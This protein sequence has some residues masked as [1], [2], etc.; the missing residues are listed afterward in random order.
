MLSGCPE[1]KV[2]GCI[3][4]DEGLGIPSRHLGLVTAEE[5]PLPEEFLHRLAAVVEQHVD[6][7]AMLESGAGHP[8]PGVQRAVPLR[9]VGHDA[10]T[11][12]VRIAVARDAAFC[13]VYADNLRLLQQAGAEIIEFSPLRDEGLPAGI[14]GLYLPGGYPEVFA[15]QLAANV[16]MKEA[17]RA[18]IE[19]GMPTYAECGG[20]IYLTQG[21]R[22]QGLASARSGHPQGV[23]LHELV[24]VYPVAASMLPRRKALGYR[25]IT[26]SADTVLGPAG[27][28]ARGHEFHYSEMEPMPAAVEC[29]YRVRRQDVD[30]GVEGFRYRHCLASYVHLH[31]GSC[32]DLPRAI[33]ENCRIFRTK[34]I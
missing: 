14:A 17:V 3:P 13:F 9:N 33:V 5:N 15:E 18:A 23:P 11:T 20:F 32:A 27:T 25:E 6:V 21:I 4:R 19:G 10:E 12:P 1:V 34:S 29:T 31:F 24:G 7:N 16:A 2:F 8:L 30:L 28:T 22:G 26:L